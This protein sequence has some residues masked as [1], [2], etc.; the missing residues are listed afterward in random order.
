MYPKVGWRHCCSY[1][2]LFHF[3]T[4][5]SNRKRWQETVNPCQKPKF[6]TIEPITMFVQNNNLWVG[7]PCVYLIYLSPEENQTSDQ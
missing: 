2:L 4:I 1:K 7:N 5:T 3:K 6:I